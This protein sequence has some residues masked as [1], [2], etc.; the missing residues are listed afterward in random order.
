MTPIPDEQLT[1]VLSYVGEVPVEPG[2]IDARS[3]QQ[4][5]SEMGTGFL[6]SR[7]A[8]GKGK[9]SKGLRELGIVESAPYS[10]DSWSTRR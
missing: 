4:R 1:D 2:P 9:G 6:Q 8:K 7:A 3:S 10:P 5:F